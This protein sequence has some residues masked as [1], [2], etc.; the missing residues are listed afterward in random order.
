M[1]ILEVKM[2]KVWRLLSILIIPLMCLGL[3]LVPGVPLGEVAASAGYNVTC[4]IEPATTSVP[5]NSTF[6]IDAVIENPDGYDVTMHNIQLDFNASY[7]TVDNVTKV[8]FP[9]D[10]GAPAIDNVNG[11]ITYDPYFNPPGK[12]NATH[13][14]SVRINCTAKALEGTSTVSWVY[15]TTPPPR[16]TKVIGGPSGVDMIGGNMSLMHSGTVR[17]GSPTLT[18]DV[19]PAGKGNVTIN[20]TIT[21]SSYPNTT[22]WSWDV[23]V[24][25]IST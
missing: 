18:V 4:S 24:A 5:P 23:V 2:T 20:G 22:N 14:T 17:I 19:T 1:F 15:K 6:S 13:I 10:M 12:T 3:V 25:I 9:S 7:F 16:Y 11:T 8:D 21:P